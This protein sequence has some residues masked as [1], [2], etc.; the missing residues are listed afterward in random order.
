MDDEMEDFEITDADLA[1]EFNPN[2]RKGKKF[3]KEQQIYGMWADN[4]HQ[5]VS[6]FDH[7]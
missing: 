4:D 2:F 6:I 7:A 3:S 1:S 5:Q